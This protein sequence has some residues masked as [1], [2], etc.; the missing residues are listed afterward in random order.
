V[1][2]RG[3]LGSPGTSRPGQLRWP[4]T[5]ACQAAVLGQRIGAVRGA[6]DKVNMNVP[7]IMVE[8]SAIMG[9][10]TAVEHAWQASSLQTEGEGE[11]VR[12]DSLRHCH[13]YS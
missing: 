10:M 4:I 12:T 13:P 9:A 5:L 8:Y 7:N 2:L 3:P 1:A 11:G 6:H